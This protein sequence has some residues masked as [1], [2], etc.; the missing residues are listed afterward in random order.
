LYPPQD[1]PVGERERTVHAWVDAITF[2]C[3]RAAARLHM[4]LLIKK[5]IGAGFCSHVYLAV[6]LDGGAACACKITDKQRMGPESADMLETE[7]DMQRQ[8]MAL[9]CGGILKLIDASIK[10]DPFRAYLVTELCAGGE[11]YDYACALGDER[12]NERMV[13]EIMRSVLRCVHVMHSSGF[14]HRDL[15]LENILLSTRDTS[16]PIPQRIRLADFG[17]ICR[18]DAGRL[19]LQCGALTLTRLFTSRHVTRL[20]RAQARQRTG[21]QRSSARHHSGPTTAAPSTCGARASCCACCSPPP[22]PPPPPHTPPH[23]DQVR[24]AHLLLPLRPPLRGFRA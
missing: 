2:I 1:A 7:A 8:L 15:K 18:T 6:Q 5:H 14:A 17:F 19:T 13:A 24:A 23:P 9:D 11:V 16:V 20:T 4:K 22:P 10:A 12:F 3:N 21:R